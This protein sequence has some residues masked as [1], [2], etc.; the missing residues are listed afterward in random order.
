MTPDKRKERLPRPT[1]TPSNGALPCEAP[2][3]DPSVAN[4]PGS[5][6]TISKRRKTPK[7]SPISSF[8]EADIGL[9]TP[10]P[11]LETRSRAMSPLIRTSENQVTLEEAE[12]CSNDK[13]IGNVGDG[14]RRF[15]NEV[16]DVQGRCKSF[17]VRLVKLNE[18]GLQ[19]AMRAS[20]FDL[21]EEGDSD[22]DDFELKTLGKEDS[23]ELT[24]GKRVGREI[25]PGCEVRLK[26][27]KMEEL[28]TTRD[29][30]NEVF[31]QTEAEVPEAFEDMS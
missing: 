20:G 21:G 1:I 10:S 7:S 29:D 3:A 2:T 5:S 23:K 9:D 28:L 11:F 14:A 17:E 15:G 30:A 16:Q 4:S 31:E 8:P 25:T 12:E 18:L 19:E 22:E 13:T 24:K 26:R 27:L 6:I